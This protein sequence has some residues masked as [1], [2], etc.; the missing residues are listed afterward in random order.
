MRK[1]F[2][3]SRV[4]VFGSLANRSNFTLWSDIDLAA[5]GILAE[6]FYAA[7]AAV[8]GMS[9]EFKMDLVGANACKFS[10]RSEIDQK[11]IDL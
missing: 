5:W 9:S 11:R 4:A 1:D 7:V 6:R 8:T 3:A 2:G 10:L